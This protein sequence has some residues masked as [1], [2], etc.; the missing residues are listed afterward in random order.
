MEKH[1]LTDVH[2]VEQQRTFV[3]LYFW[4][5]FFQSVVL[6]REDITTK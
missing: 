6:I 5:Y 2:I 1:S 3:R 4:V